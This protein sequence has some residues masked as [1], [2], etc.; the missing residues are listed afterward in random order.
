VATDPLVLP[1]AHSKKPASE[2]PAFFTVLTCVIR[3][4]ACNDI[5]MLRPSWT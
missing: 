4:L 3:S 5:H 2:T 1:G